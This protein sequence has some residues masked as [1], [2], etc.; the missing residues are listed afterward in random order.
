MKIL[1]QR[2]PTT[3]EL[4]YK[5]TRLGDEKNQLNKKKSSRSNPEKREP[6]PLT[7]NR[8]TLTT[9]SLGQ[10]KEGTNSASEIVGYMPLRKDFDIEYDNDAELLLS[11]ME[12]N[13]N[14]LGKEETINN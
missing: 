6:F 8:T 1:S 10:N 11:E 14:K 2:N 12:F 13:G 3:L 9:T 7:G 4:R 5:N